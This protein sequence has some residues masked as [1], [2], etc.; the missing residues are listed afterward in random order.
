M[1]EIQKNGVTCRNGQSPHLKYYL[2]LK[3]KEDVESIGLGL[4]RRG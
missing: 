2:W 4:Q 3:T 1:G